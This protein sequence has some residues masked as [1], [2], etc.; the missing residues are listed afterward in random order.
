MTTEQLENLQAADLIALNIEPLTPVAFTNEFFENF[1]VFYNHDNECY[2]YKNR[3]N[4]N[5]QF[6]DISIEDVIEFERL[7]LQ[8]CLENCINWQSINADPLLVDNI[9]VWN[10]RMQQLPENT[11]HII[12]AKSFKDDVVENYVVWYTIDENGAHVPYWY[13]NNITNISDE[14]DDLPKVVKTL[15]EANMYLPS[16]SKHYWMGS[17][18]YSMPSIILFLNDNMMILQLVSAKYGTVFVDNNDIIYEYSWEKTE[19]NFPGLK[20]LLEKQFSNTPFE[21]FYGYDRK[22]I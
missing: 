19:R 15:N 21:N 13:N 22:A 11:F 2:W 4:T 12:E 1:I 8:K 16:T 17:K 14:F 7:I 20:K 5:I 3:L 6:Y 10:L 9:L 18:I